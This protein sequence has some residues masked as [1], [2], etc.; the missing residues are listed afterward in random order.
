MT[1]TLTP[2]TDRRGGPRHTDTNR[3]LTKIKRVSTLIGLG[4]GIEAACKRTNT[5]A[6]TIRKWSKELGVKFTH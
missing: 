5:S 4:L 1:T 2:K 3:K 6:F